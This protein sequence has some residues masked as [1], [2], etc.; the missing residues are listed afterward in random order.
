MM[1]R[2]TWSIMV[3]PTTISRGYLQQKIARDLKSLLASSNLLESLSP[4]HS[5]DL[6]DA[7]K[8]GHRLN[9]RW[10]GKNLITG[11]P[12]ASQGGAEND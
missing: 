11:C 12:N 1:P 3:W 5:P 10:Q 9:G 6:L 8:I 4:C 2:A 7:S